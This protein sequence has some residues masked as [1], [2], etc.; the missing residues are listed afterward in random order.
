MLF[1]VHLVL[2]GG[3]VYQAGYIPRL[4]GVALAITGLGYLLTSLR[5]FVAPT[6]QVDFA[7][8]TFYGELFFM[9]WLL[10]RGQ[11]I[12]EPGPGTAPPPGELML[13]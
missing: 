1:G 5:P 6:L 3:L 11:R 9:G 2:L 7:L 10:V 13:T 12:A 8:Y 4:L